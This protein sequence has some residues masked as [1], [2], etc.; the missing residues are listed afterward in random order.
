M[1][2]FGI[3]D[4]AVVALAKVVHDLDLKE[5]RYAM[6]EAA[7]IGRLGE[8]LRASFSDDAE[9]LEHGVVMMEALYRSFATGPGGRGKKAKK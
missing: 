9:L 3:S 6:A 2:R 7:A 1:D 4:G 5:A 8:G